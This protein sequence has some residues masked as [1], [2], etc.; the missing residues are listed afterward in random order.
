MSVK[1][2]ERLG[3]R[4]REDIGIQSE[5]VCECVCVWVRGGWVRECLHSREALGCP[6]QGCFC[7]D[8]CRDYGQ[9]PLFTQSMCAVTRW[10]THKKKVYRATAGITASKASVP[11]FKRCPVV[12]GDILE[13]CPLFA[14]FRHRWSQHEGISNLTFVFSIPLFLKKQHITPPAVDNY[15]WRCFQRNILSTKTKLCLQ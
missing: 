12:R 14:R 9:I 8:Q 7:K 4:V 6:R 5:F 10:C 2:F 3:L 15:A 13:A 1:V 11:G